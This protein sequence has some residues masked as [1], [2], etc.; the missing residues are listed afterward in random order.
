MTN[1][2]TADQIALLT[3]DAE[4]EYFSPYYDEDGEDEV[5][6]DDEYSWNHYTQSNECDDWDEQDGTWGYA[7]GSYVGDG[8]SDTYVDQDDYEYQQA[9]YA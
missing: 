2:F 9:L 8:Y 1:E 3:E 4:R 7:G 6:D 5:S